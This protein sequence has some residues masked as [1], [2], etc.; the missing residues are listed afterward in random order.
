MKHLLEMEEAVEE[1]PLDLEIKL[2]YNTI[3]ILFYGQLAEWSKA[4]AW[5]A[6]IIFYTFPHS[7]LHFDT[8]FLQSI[9]NI[10]TV[11]Y[12]SIIFT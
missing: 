1:L 3:P 8:N 4:H 9:N 12:T 7:Y 2:Q 5:N 11:I 10:F 6:A